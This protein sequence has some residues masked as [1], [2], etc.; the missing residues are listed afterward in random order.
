MNPAYFQLD[1]YT[2]QPQWVFNYWKLNFIANNTLLY[3]IGLEGAAIREKPDYFTQFDDLDTLLKKYSLTKE[4]FNFLNSIVAIDYHSWETGLNFQFHSHTLVHYCL[5]Q[6]PIHKKNLF[7][8]WKDA[9][10][11]FLKQTPSGTVL[12]DEGCEAVD[13]GKAYLE[14][15]ICSA[16]STQCDREI[17][18]ALNYNATLVEELTQHFQSKP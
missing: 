14:N 11:S 17:L 2:N 12:M 5:G 15:L 18:A 8:L 13:R 4:Q 1:A 10:D 16:E 7:S 3:Y 6:F 9:I